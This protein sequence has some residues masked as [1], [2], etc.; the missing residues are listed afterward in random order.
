MIRFACVDVSFIFYFLKIDG[1]EAGRLELFKTEIIL[2]NKN[3]CNLPNKFMF[4]LSSFKS[5]FN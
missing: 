2:K 4:L 3:N 5:N 1:V